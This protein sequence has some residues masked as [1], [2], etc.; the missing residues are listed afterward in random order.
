MIPYQFYYQLV[1]LGLLWLFVMLHSAWPSRCATAQGTP[2][3]PI[4][5]RRQRSKEPQPFAGLTRQPHCALCEHE[6][7]HPQP[8]PPVRPDP[9]PSPNRRPR[10]I[11]TSMHFC[12]HVDCAY[13]GWRGLGNLRAHGHPNGSPWRPF[14]CTACKGDFLETHGTIFHGKRVSVELIIRVLACLA[15]GVGIRGTARVFAVAPTTVLQGLVEAAD[16]LQAFSQYVLH[17]VRVTQVQ[18]DELSALLSA[19]KDGAGSAVEAIER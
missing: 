16:H 17:N 2:A 8:R 1:G 9:I 7:A 19:V 14:H 13:R 6:T 15:E 18:L 10:A 12:P 3:T 11:D 5:P 4:T